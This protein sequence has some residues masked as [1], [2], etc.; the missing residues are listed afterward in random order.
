MLAE[1]LPQALT[2]GVLALMV[3]LPACLPHTGEVKRTSEGYWLDVSKL[4][5]ASVRYRDD[6]GKAKIVPH[7]IVR[8][9]L[10]GKEI[11]LSALSTEAQLLSAD[12]G[13]TQALTGVTS[14]ALA[15]EN[16]Y[17]I[18]KISFY[19]Q[20][21]DGKKYFCQLQNIP[22]GSKHEFV[23]SDC[24]ENGQEP[25]Y[26]YFRH[27][28]TDVKHKL[29]KK[30]LQI[31]CQVNYGDEQQLIRL[32]VQNGTIVDDRGSYAF[33][34]Q[35]EAMFKIKCQNS[36]THNPVL[37]K[38]KLKQGESKEVK[39]KDFTKL[40]CFKFTDGW[41]HTTWK[42]VVGKVANACKEEQLLRFNF[43]TADPTRNDDNVPSYLGASNMFFTDVQ[44]DTLLK[45]I[46]VLSHCEDCVPTEVQQL[47]CA[48]TCAAP[49]YAYADK[50]DR[51]GTHIQ[52]GA[53]RHYSQR[54]FCK[55]NAQGLTSLSEQAALTCTALPSEGD[56]DEQSLPL[57]SAIV[58]AG[59]VCVD[60]SPANK[61]TISAVATCDS[62]LQFFFKAV[63]ATQ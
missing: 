4:G 13:E 60:F 11:G 58:Q 63:K 24:E 35:A 53:R 8:L 12:G 51:P 1:K 52:A 9:R 26:V 3:C 55:D 56:K 42:N 29:S 18:N 37:G 62:K 57:T 46:V 32:A 10:K 43:S 48:A 15:V 31:D 2:C 23:V 47:H 25:D 38:E 61:L 17:I 49:D 50:I 39:I 34:K 59:K 33:A 5:L 16:F 45:D 54:L 21:S 20:S 28:Y 6:A 14:P 41:L 19:M 7:N 30:I 22:L 27:R 40:A 44:E 36:F